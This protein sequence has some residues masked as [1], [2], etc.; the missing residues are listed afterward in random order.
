[1]NYIHFLKVQSKKKEKIEFNSDHITMYKIHVLTM[2]TRLERHMAEIYIHEIFGR[3]RDEL[4]H[5]IATIVY[6]P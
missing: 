1:M 6:N 2:K 5:S 4:E 3:F